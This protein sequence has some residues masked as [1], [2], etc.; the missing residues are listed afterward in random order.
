MICP[1]ENCGREFNPWVISKTGKSYPR[2]FCSHSCATQKRSVSRCA[3]CGCAVT[4]GST[5]C[6]SCYAQSHSRHMTTREGRLCLLRK[7]RISDSIKP[8]ELERGLAMDGGHW[9]KWLRERKRSKTELR[10]SHC[11]MLCSALDEGVKCW[12]VECPIRAEPISE[13]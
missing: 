4:R 8:Q 13:V 11:G 3:N 1:N 6:R 5:Q 9:K 12:I 2:K 7:L 10:C